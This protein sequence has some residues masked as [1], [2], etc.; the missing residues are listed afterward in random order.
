MQ[1]SKHNGR[2]LLSNPCYSIMVSCK[3]MKQIKKLETLWKRPITCLTFKDTVQN[4]CIYCDCKA[5]VPRIH[6]R[7]LI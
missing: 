5:K 7:V 4:P 2:Y 1:L 6:I 3:Y